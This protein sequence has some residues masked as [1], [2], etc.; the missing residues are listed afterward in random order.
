[1]KK[2]Y[3]NLVAGCCCML[4][5]LC[6]NSTFAQ[7][8]ITGKVTSSEN[9]EPVLGA[10]VQVK[11]TSTGTVTDVTGAFSL[12]V[13]ENAT[14]VVSF[15]GFKPLEV[16]VG[17]SSTMDIKL[18]TSASS[19]NELVVT[20]YT[21]QQRKDIVG[22]VSTVKAKELVAVPAGNAE[23][24]LQGRV[25][26]LTVLSS[27]Q[28]GTTSLVRIRGFAS[29]AGN[30]PLY[31]VD[32][33]PTFS[34]E[35]INSFDIE[36]TTVLKDAGSASIY[37]ARAS[38]GV[39]VITTKRGTRGKLQVTYDGSYGW[40]TPGK[41]FKMLTPQ[42]TADYTWTALRNAGKL[43]PNGNPIHDQYGN[44]PNAVLPD[45]IRVGDKNGVF[46]GDPAID[47]S[48]YNVDFN[49]GPIYQIVRANKVGTDWYKEITRTAPIQQHSVGMSGG[50]DNSRF[51]VGFGY[52]NQEGVV[53]N[54]YLR[55][56]TIRVNSEFTVHNRV[57]IGENIQIA[58]RDNPQLTNLDEG[59]AISLAYRMN[60]LIP[61]YDVMGGWAGTAA[62]GFNNPSN[63]VANQTR[64]KDNKGHAFGV[65]GNV[66]AEVDLLKDLTFRTSFGGGFFSFYANG[67]T[68]RTYE[69]SENIGNDQLFEAGGYGHSWTWTN[70]A[71]YQHTFGIHDFKGLLGIEAIRDGAGRNI[72]GTGLNPFTN[73]VSYRTLTTTQSS[74][75]TV[76]SDGSP[77]NDIF[78]IFGKV[79]YT[80]MDKYLVSLVLRR[81]GS[82]NFGIAD[83]YGT[84]PAIS[85]G[86]RISQENFMKNVPWINELKIRGGWGKMGNQ[87]IDLNNQYNLYAASARFS[88]Y[89]IDGSSTSTF[90]GINKSRIGNPEGRW[91]TNITSNVGL[92][93]TL[94]N[95]SMDI[96]FDWYHKRTNDLLFNP[97]L[98]ASVGQVTYPTINVA[99]MLNTGIDLQIIKRGNF[100]KDWRYEANLTLTT[101]TNEITKLAEGVDYFD[102]NSFGST[103]IG[104]FTRNQVGQPIS[105]FFGYNVVGLFQDENDVKNSPTQDGAAPGRFKFQDVN[106]DKKISPDDRTFF[107]DPNPRLTSGLDLTIGYKGFDFNIFLYT[108]QGSKVINYTRWFTDFFPSF[109][110]QAISDRVK[111]S[112]TPQNTG[113]SIPI[114][115]DVSNFSTNTQP[116]S[117]Y[118][119]SGSY[120]RARNVQLSYTLPAYTS[121]TI[122]MEKLKVYVQTTNLFTI[123]K[124]KGLDPAVSGV[125]TNFGVDYG[126][127]P[128]TRQILLGVSA[129]F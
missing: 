95:N 89:A 31:I 104:T 17:S 64:A 106:G 11:G 18:E 22:A 44:G 35:N 109:P 56:Y 119:E 99:S 123:T 114:F 49:K 14:L 42:E 74:G 120:I 85:G 19:L 1:M 50:S 24:Q 68:S 75:R 93:V 6:F 122:G 116:N 34:I 94:F 58:Y 101:Y 73:A 118:M 88:A 126:N 127:Y 48:L 76:D 69:N 98:P 37:G 36:T 65:F 13:P 39:I 82:S 86:W 4:L 32:G 84:F 103:R 23:Q 12:S 112:W 29:F 77:G 87:R 117:F 8:K 47:P 107:G 67:I 108:V 72:N 10:T 90:E 28:P 60:P 61:V 81:D 121:R 54:T 66:Y 3:H 38:A 96:I 43:E 30:E 52:Y 111:G 5:L 63:P 62:K 78:S 7:K 83:R 25:A 2:I 33:V 71:R 125:D 102:G 26:G 20:G 70:T 21:T 46:E 59:N 115:E 15:V 41:G 79:D 124:Y 55:R 91:E 113:A 51:F 97:E 40:Q 128:L 53:L 27:G 129:T 9:S 110:G 45:Y 57:R 80:L 92:D 100:G 105:S 16:T